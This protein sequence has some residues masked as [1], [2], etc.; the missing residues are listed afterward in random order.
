MAVPDEVQDPEVVDVSEA[1]AENV[2]AQFQEV[3]TVNVLHYVWNTPPPIIIFLK[4]RAE[5]DDLHSYF[6][7]H[8]VES[9]AYLAGKCGLERKYA[10]RFIMA[11]EK[12]VLVATQ[13]E[14]QN[15]EKQLNVS[16]IPDP[17]PLCL[18]MPACLASA[19]PNIWKNGS[20]GWGD[21][22]GRRTRFW[23]SLEQNG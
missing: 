15:L 5:V 19:R 6:L 23:S 11:G 21:M 18:V 1:G 14:L 10:I 9:V 3:E 22:G 4:T 20:T 7:Q 17:A 13:A 12:D 2:G 16:V 8:S